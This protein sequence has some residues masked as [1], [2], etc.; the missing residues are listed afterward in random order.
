MSI[1]FDDALRIARKSIG[2]MTGDM[3]PEVLRFESQNGFNFVFRTVKGIYSITIDQNGS[4]GRF[5]REDVPAPQQPSY[6]PAQR[7]SYEDEGRG[8]WSPQGGITQQDAVERALSY[9]G[10]GQVAEVE[11]S[12][13]GWKVEIYRGMMKGK[14]EVFVDPSG[15]VHTKKRSRLDMLDFDFD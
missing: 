3:R 11:P 15:A 6:Q 14:V 7:P 5:V 13:G 2:D 8:A 10:G 4:V 9:V 12:R 1:A